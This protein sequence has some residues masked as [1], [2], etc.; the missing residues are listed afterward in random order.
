MHHITELLAARASAASSSIL[1][2][3][4]PT[5]VGKTGLCVDLAE[6]VGGEIIS[7]DSRQVYRGL[8]IGTAKPTRE[9]R[10]GIPH[11]FIDELEL[12]EPF[13][14]G[15]FARAAEA[16][17]DDVRA[18]GRVPIVTGG[19][20]LYIEALVRGIVDVPEV[21]PAVR[22]ALTAELEANG[23]ELLW[24]ELL[25]CD[26][27]TAATMDPT[28]TQR[29]VRALEVAR[30]TGRTLSDFRAEQ[31][32]PRHT[33]DVVVLARPRDV[34]VQRIET[35]IAAMLEAGLL[36]EVRGV[37]DAGH[38]AETNALQTIGYREPIR[39]LRGEIDYDEMVRLLERNTR[40]YAKRQRTWFR[41]YP[42]WLEL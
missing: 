26:P 15:A 25:A 23:A 3:A 4:G 29:L 41:R 16:R 13:S 37:L 21:D 40:R 22:L 28:K 27:Q 6:R 36:D 20:T 30:G 35:R 42:E 9:E 32:A 38:D 18:R 19:S 5:A 33:Y 14:A 39:H 1:L 7:A 12:G 8:D 10:R 11:H 34:L 2:V 17:I 24:D 31:P